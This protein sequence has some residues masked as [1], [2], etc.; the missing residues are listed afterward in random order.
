MIVTLCVTPRMRI[1]VMLT[2]IDLDDEP[3]FEADKIDDKPV[4]RRLT[5]KVKPSPSP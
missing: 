1:E 5:T 4:T 3:M 2:A